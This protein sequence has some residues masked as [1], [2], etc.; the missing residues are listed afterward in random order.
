MTGVQT[1]AEFGYGHTGRMPDCDNR[2][3]D[4]SAAA[5]IHKLPARCE[6]RGRGR[7]G[8]SPTGFRIWAWQ[9]SLIS[10]V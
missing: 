10:N 6:K 7:E 3:R 4:A 1:R 8:Y 9:T 5:I 2:G